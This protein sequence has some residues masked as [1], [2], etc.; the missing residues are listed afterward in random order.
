MKTQEQTILDEL[1]ELAQEGAGK[2]LT[3]F[4]LFA[5]CQEEIRAYMSNDHAS[6][7]SILIHL[8]NQFEKELN[9]E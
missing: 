2:E 8:L 1:K 3:E 4:Y 7:I 5:M 6:S 9:H